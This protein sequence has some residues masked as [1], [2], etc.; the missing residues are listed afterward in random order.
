LFP[1]KLCFS[2]SH[3]NHSPRSAR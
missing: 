3:Q 1:T 2:K